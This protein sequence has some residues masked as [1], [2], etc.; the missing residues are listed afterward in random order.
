MDSDEEIEDVQLWKGV[1]GTIILINAF[2]NSKY[3]IFPVAHVATCRLIRQYLR[4]SSSQNVSVCVYGTEDTATTTFDSK[5]VIEI[6]PL[7]TPTLEDFKKLKN[8]DISSYAEAKE[9]KLSDVLWHCNKMFS[10]F[11][12]QLSSRTIIL[13]TELRSPPIAA[14]HKPTF[15]KVMDLVDCNIDLKI[16][17]L[18]DEEYQIDEFYKNLLLEANKGQDYKLPLPM[19]DSKE[20]ENLM[21][22]QSHRHLAVA[23]MDFEIG[24]GLSIGVGI[25]SLLKKSG[26]T[27]RKKSNLERDTNAIVTKITK[28]MKHSVVQEEDDIEQGVPKEV[29]LLKSEVLHYQ[30]YGGERVQFTDQEMKTIR[31]PFGPSMLKLLGF[32][33]A[34]LMCKEKWYFK[35]S[36]FLFPNEGSLEGSTVAFKALHKACKDMSVVAICVLCTRVNSK[37]VIVALSPTSKP[38]GLD[39]D[40]GF[41]VII[42]PFMESVRDVPNIVEDD[43]PVTVN[44]ANKTVMGDI[45]NTMRFDYKPYMFESPKEQSHYRALESLALEEDLDPFIDTTHPDP[46]IYKDIR[47][48]LFEEIFGPFGALAIKRSASANQSGGSK[49]TKVENGSGIDENLLQDRISSQKVNAYNVAQLKDILRFKN[50]KEMPALTGLKKAEL[51]DLVYKYCS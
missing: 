15:K 9:L 43:E 34:G 10:N 33:P 39:V 8:F 21:L 51:V 38:L 40:I 31:N 28:T 4:L 6:F 46:N 27:Q 41:D 2:G 12:K 11:K 48:D 44:E 18:S 50:I 49:R 20:I 16:I 14:D 5:S 47:E 26:Y 1:P 35:M 24:N 25:Y 30:E 45:L 7:T 29:P 13:L 22:I 19:W 42:I 37:P 32:K 3:K 17:N 36:Y 23:K